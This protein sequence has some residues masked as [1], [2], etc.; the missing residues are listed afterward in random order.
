MIDNHKMYVS[1]CSK[2]NIM[3]KKL[4]RPLHYVRSIIRERSK[5]KKR[6]SRWNSVRDSFIE[7]YPT[8]AACGSKNRLQVH[9]IAP[10]HLYPELELDIK[11]LIVLCMDKN[12]CH[13][14]I[15]HGGSF[16]CYNPKVETHAKRFLMEK[17]EKVRKSIVEV[18]RTIRQ[19]E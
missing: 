10:F 6:S 16:K 7:S 12:E 17:D 11:N 19:K 8:C 4:I 5:S 14:E 18:C 1:A 3:I 13:L 9:H 15:G 2:G